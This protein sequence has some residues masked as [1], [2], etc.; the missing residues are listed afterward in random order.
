MTYSNAWRLTEAQTKSI[1][2]KLEFWFNFFTILDQLIFRVCQ[3]HYLILHLVH[4]NA[5]TV[6]RSGKHLKCWWY[7]TTKLIWINGKPSRTSL[8]FQWKTISRKQNKSRKNY[9][10]QCYTSVW[11]VCNSKSIHLE[12][13]QKIK[14][15]PTKYE[16]FEIN[17]EV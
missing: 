1:K 2:M 17:S 4:R 11:F 16:I 12:L 13:R 6:Q 10:H 7:K 5:H 15:S 9:I 14:I 8:L 3:W